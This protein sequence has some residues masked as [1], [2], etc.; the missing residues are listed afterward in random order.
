[1]QELS[2]I[3]TRLGLPP[4]EP[5]SLKPL[6]GDGSD[7]RFFRLC[8]TDGRR[9]VAV[10]PADRAARSLAEARSAFLIG[11]HLADRGVPVP[12]IH[13]FD[14]QSSALFCEDWGDDHL[15]AWVAARR[16]RPE[17]VVAMYR[18]VVEA[19]ALMQVEGA[20]NWRPEWSWDSPLY[21]RQVMLER[22]SGYFAEAFV[23]GY[24]GIQNP[25]AGLTAEFIVL[26]DRCARLDHRF[27]LHRDFQSRNIL[28]NDGA[29]CFIDF[30]AGRLGP[31]GY[32]LASLLRDPYVNLEQAVQDEVFAH[33]LESLSTRCAIDRILF[34]EGYRCLALQRNL[35]ILGAFAFLCLRKGKPFFRQ[36]IPV[37]LA[38]LRRLLAS[39]FGGDFPVLAGLVERL[40]G[41]LE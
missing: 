20:V 39:P 32:D 26:A 27:F 7:R 28:V 17:S 19:L 12:R 5:G 38:S 36:Y 10:L 21:D 25:P 4:L 35:Q 29:F 8:L 33:Y 1:M 30:Q 3:A 14:R 37:A 2:A 9:L 41:R 23:R 34:S 15:A 6:S 22:E 18:R 24:A 16:G 31:P 40:A 13:G 11:G